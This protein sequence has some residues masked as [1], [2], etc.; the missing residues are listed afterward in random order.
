M[1]KYDSKFWVKSYDKHVSKTLKYPN[2]GCGEIFKERLTK[3]PEKPACH[4]RDRTIS[5]KELWDY[6]QRFASFLQKNGLEKGDVVAINI[7]NSPQFLIAHFGTWMAGGVSSGCSPLLSDD[8]IAYQLNDSKAKFLVTLDAIHD[9]MLCKK[10]VLDNVPNLET[11]IPTNIS[12]YMGFSKF[13]V[14]IAKLFKKIPKGKMRPYPGKNVVKFQDV[15]QTEIDYKEV[16]IDIDKDLAQLQ[17]T[18]GTTGRPKGTKLTH[19]NML[20]NLFQWDN[21]L[22]R[23]PGEDMIL[24]AFPYF[25]IAGLLVMDSAVFLSATQILIANPRDTDNII[26]EIIDKQPTVI[27]NVPTLYMMI[28]NNPNSRTIPADILDNIDLYVSGAAPFP[29]ESIREFESSMRADNKL[30]EVYGMTE[31]APLLSANPFYGQKKI[32]TVGLPLPDTE[33][34]FINVETGEDVELGKAGEIIAK[35]PQVTP[36]YFEKPEANEK[37]FTDGW[38]HTGDVGVMDEDG[39]IK[40]VDRTKDMINVSGYKVYSVHVEDIM[41]KYPDIEIIALV[42]ITDKNRPGSEIVKAY[43]TLK[44]GIE[45]TEEVKE[46][47]LEYAKKNLSKYEVPKIWE[48][49]TELPLTSIGKVLKKELREENQ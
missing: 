29:A 20:S 23:K 16:S 35:G 49:R 12:E 40:I 46:K 38:F 8:E 43:I 1:S 47:I 5:Y 33:I 22:N 25:H 32:G 30:L 18:G 4:F 17:Y 15:F 10:G 13:K 31:A 26:K 36:G 27:A 6:I 45:P 41:T 37:T 48:F 3:F 21:W 9:K 7:P 39:F 2:K 19:K 44:E 11:I 24:S 42:G 34:R 28:L 14:F